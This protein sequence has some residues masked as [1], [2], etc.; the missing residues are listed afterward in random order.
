MFSLLKNATIRDFGGYIKVI[1]N[2]RSNFI[3]EAV[4]VMNK[5]LQLECMDINL[6]SM[7]TLR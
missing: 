5:V 2:T 1:G 3:K 4:H 7:E 6:F